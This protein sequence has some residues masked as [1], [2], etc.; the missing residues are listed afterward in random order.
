MLPEVELI[1]H[2]IAFHF[3][4]QPFLPALAPLTCLRASMTWVAASL[5]GG[6]CSYVS[7]SGKLGKGGGGPRTVLV[8]RDGGNG[9]DAD[10]GDSGGMAWLGCGGY[11]GGREG[12]EV[13]FPSCDGLGF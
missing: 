13:G 5:G 7:L 9:A 2:P 6:K 8:L 3:L 10:G 11:E 1:V 4:L 12:E